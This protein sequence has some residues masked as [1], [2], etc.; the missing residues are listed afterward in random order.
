MTG[1]VVYRGASLLD[2]APIAVVLTGPADNRKTGAMWQT[3][4]L[5]TDVHPLHA[6]RTGADAS[7]CGTCPHRGILQ[8]NGRVVGRT[9][10]VNVQHAPAAIYRAY[11]RGLYPDA[12][13]AAFPERIDVRIGAYGDPATVPAT[14]WEALLRQA[15]GHTG[16]TH[17]WRT[18]DPQL[19]NWCMASVDSADEQAEAAALG[20]RTF[21]V[22]T[23]HEPRLYGEIICPASAEAGHKTTCLRCRLCCGKTRSAGPNVVIEAHGPAQARFFTSRHQLVLGL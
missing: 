20:W 19:Q 4:I 18:C 6:T 16:Y 13:F 15:K 17:L 2:G 14:V 1:M 21:R 11:R 23:V 5:R 3:W 7:I 10:Y 8:R 9:C 12:D 22:R